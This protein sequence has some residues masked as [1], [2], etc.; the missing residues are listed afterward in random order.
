MHS[1]SCRLRDPTGFHEEQQQLWHELTEP[2][3]L[4]RSARIQT[5]ASHPFG[6]MITLSTTSGS[7]EL[8]GPRVLTAAE[9]A[10]N[11]DVFGA[12]VHAGIETGELRPDADATG[13]A[14]LFERLLVGFSIQAADQ[15]PGS[16]LNGAITGAVT[17]WDSAG[18]D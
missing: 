18:R 12:C 2:Q 13:L 11:C 14:A 9:R 16:A 4:R 7:A 6:C 8:D 10:A 1:G 15:V 3:A 5:D 17:A